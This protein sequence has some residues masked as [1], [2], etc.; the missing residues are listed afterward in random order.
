MLIS[1]TILTVVTGIFGAAMFQV[2][3]IQRFW[4]DDVKAVREVRHAG[5][6]FSGDALNATNV[7]DAGG[8]RLTCTPSPPVEQV[9]LTWRDSSGN[10]HNSVYSVT[11]DE[12]RRDFDDTGIELVMASRVVP[13]SISFT[14]CGNI[15]RL[16]MNV[17][18]D[19]DTTD[20]LDLLTY[21]RELS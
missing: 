8:T 2:L 1:V 19:R 7:L 14:L 10:D 11:G 3:S 21:M 20:T 4:T 13:G 17:L 15:L 12:L 6:W 16:T 18:A 9:K 5:S